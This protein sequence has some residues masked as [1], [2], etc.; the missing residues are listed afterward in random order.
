MSDTEPEGLWMTIAELARLKGISRQSAAERVDRLERSGQLSTRR[1]GR[2]RLVD[3]ASYDHAVGQAGDA[4]REIGA[5]MRRGASTAAPTAALRDAQTDRAQYEAKLKALDFAERTRQ[6]IPVKGEHGIEAA[7][8]RV[9]EVLIRDVGAPLQWISKLYEAARQG[10]PQLR[11]VLRE[12][13]NTMRADMAKHLLELATE[14]T[15]AEEAGIEIDIH[16]EE[17]TTP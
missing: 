12:M 4:A 3:L 7:L 15:L 6:L 11:R 14:A 9:S 10:E 1:Q 5:E 13:I 8:I 2:S 16:F 17:R